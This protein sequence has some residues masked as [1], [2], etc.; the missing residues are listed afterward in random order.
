M[1]YLESNINVIRSQVKANRTYKEISN[2]FKQSFLEVRRGFSER[3]LRSF[4]S[5]HEIT[6]MNETEI[7]AIIQDCVSEVS[8]LHFI[9]REINNMLVETYISF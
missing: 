2:L 9:R 3:N 8:F 5:K 4:C 6:K 1:E 7:D